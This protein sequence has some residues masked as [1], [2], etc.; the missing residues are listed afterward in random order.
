[1]HQMELASSANP[2]S[3]PAAMDC[4]ASNHQSIASNNHESIEAI[5][6]ASLARGRR[7]GSRLHV[8]LALL[9]IEFA[10]LLGRCIL[11]LLVLGDEIVHVGLSFSKFHLVHAL[12]SVPM[13]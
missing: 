8:V 1:M 12:P 6:I 9:L 2:D 3:S 10:L 5:A 11:V 13:Q 4:L 7:N